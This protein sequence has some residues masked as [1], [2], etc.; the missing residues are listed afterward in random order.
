MIY[1][2]WIISVLIIMLISIFTWYHYKS[3]NIK[4]NKKDLILF[5]SAFLMTGIVLFVIFNRNYLYTDIAKIIFCYIMLQILAVIDYKYHIIPNK[6]IIIAALFGVVLLAIEYYIF[7]NQFIYILAD[8]AIGALVCFGILFIVSMICKTGIGMG[9]VKLVGVVGLIQGIINTYNILFYALVVLLIYI[10]IM[11]I[12]KK[13]NRKTQI[14]FAPYVYI[15]F[16][17]SMLFNII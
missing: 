9:D 6:I 12:L 2:I 15:G 7:P 16:C 14:P 5:I 17:I 1:L 8:S 13:V 11:W 4:E 10:L 3:I